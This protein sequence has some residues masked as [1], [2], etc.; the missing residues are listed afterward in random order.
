M[1]KL[2]ICTALISAAFLSTS[3]MAE[4]YSFK[5]KNNTQSKI[6]KVMVSEDGKTWG[7]FDIG[8]GIPVGETVTLEWAESAN[9]ESCE[10]H[11]KAVFADGSESEPSK[12]DF[13][14]ELE[15]EF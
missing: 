9:G 6:T 11:V 14:S 12:F 5:M 1:R 13:C 4:G 15:L 3:A 2:L 10:Q 7:Q 8:K